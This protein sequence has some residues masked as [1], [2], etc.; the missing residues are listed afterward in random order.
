MP[1][2]TREDFERALAEIK[3]AFGAVTEALEEY[4][5]NGIISYGRHFAHL[6]DTC[7]TLVE[8]VWGWPLSTLRACLHCSELL[9]ACEEC[10]VTGVLPVCSLHVHSH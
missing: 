2:V 10:D 3:P 6:Q 4:R 8:Q 9:P 5:L 7:A 1:Q